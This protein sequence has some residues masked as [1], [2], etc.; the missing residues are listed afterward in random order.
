ML[1]IKYNNAS[2]QWHVGTPINAPFRGDVLSVQAD[3]DELYF[4]LKHV[5]PMKVTEPVVQFNQADSKDIVQAINDK[6]YKER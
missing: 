5:L 4:A 2:Y 1:Y 3:G 6:Y